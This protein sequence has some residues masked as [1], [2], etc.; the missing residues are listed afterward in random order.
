M[1]GTSIPGFGPQAQET[2]PP[3]PP[4]AIDVQDTAARDTKETVARKLIPNF[5]QITPTLYR[6]GQ[7]KKGGFEKLAKMGIAIVVDLRGDRDSERQRVTSLRM[8][9]VPMHWQC[10][11]PRDRIFAQFLTLLR[12]H[13][14][15]KVFV[16]CRLGDDRT[17]MMI[18]AYRMAEE[19]WSPEQALEEMKMYG[20]NFAHRRLICPGL[21]H[22]EEHFLQRLQKQPEF[23]RLRSKERP[24]APGQPPAPPQPPT[25]QPP[26]PQSPTPG[27]PPAPQASATPEFQTSPSFSG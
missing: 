1:A 10:S 11:F 24:P 3:S 6:G 8:Q 26:L 23:E 13:P 22:Y 12:D 27:Q 25:P 14:G 2:P 21:S 15:K 17:A 5:G 4:P 7:P 16:H 20:F 9:Y 19:G 18:A